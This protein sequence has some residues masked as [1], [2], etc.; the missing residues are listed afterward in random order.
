MAKDSSLIVTVIV[1]TPNNLKKSKEISLGN[2]CQ[3]FST[4][5]VTGNTIGGLSF[6][7]S[8]CGEAVA[9]N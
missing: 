7:P 9:S 1:P 6:L 5:W 2:M 4:R 3:S 8:A